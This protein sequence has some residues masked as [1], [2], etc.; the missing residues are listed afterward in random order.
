MEPGWQRRLHNRSHLAQYIECEPLRISILL[1]CIF[2]ARPMHQ[3]MVTL[4]VVFHSSLSE[5]LLY[6]AVPSKRSTTANDLP[7]NREFVPSH[8]LHSCSSTIDHPDIWCY[9]LIPWL[10]R[11]LWFTGSL[12][13]QQYL[14]ASCNQSL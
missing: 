4:I 13:S 6:K 7:L 12:A 8:P 3:S 10:W 5:P 14:R 9:I 2:E 1:Y 11:T